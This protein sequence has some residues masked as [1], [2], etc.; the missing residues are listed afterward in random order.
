MV[1][2]PRYPV[3][4]FLFTRV[5][6]VVD[7]NETGV[8]YVQEFCTPRELLLKNAHLKKIQ[9]RL[10]F[11]L[12]FCD[13]VCFSSHTPSKTDRG[14]KNCHRHLPRVCCLVFYGR[15]LMLA[16]LPK[17]E[18]HVPATHWFDQHLHGMTLIKKLTYI[19]IYIYI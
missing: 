14:K 12:N 10:H 7:C 6:R 18:C 8:V 1:K 11:S 17:K 13:R 15:Q 9:N 16:V 4:P 5:L 19:Y 2:T 3:Y